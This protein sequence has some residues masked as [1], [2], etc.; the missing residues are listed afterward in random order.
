MRRHR[1]VN[2]WIALPLFEETL[3]TARAKLGPEHNVTLVTMAN[4]ATAYRAAGKLE[5]A[6]P[7]LQEPARSM[8]K[9]RFQPGNAVGQQ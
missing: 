8:E 5:R 4:L 9:K 1:S 2:Q 6:L 7:L 3:K